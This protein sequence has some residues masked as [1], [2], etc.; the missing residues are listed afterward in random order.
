MEA[1]S[2]IPELQLLSVWKT[3]SCCKTPYRH[4]V[5]AEDCWKMVLQRKREG[6]RIK[7]SE[8]ACRIIKQFEEEKRTKT[9]TRNLKWDGLDKNYVKYG[10]LGGPA[11]I[12][13][14]INSPR[15]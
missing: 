11:G 14:V 1:G 13:T 15:T 9:P 7:M 3:D 5:T 10:G 12:R 2:G 6:E 8:R 4:Y